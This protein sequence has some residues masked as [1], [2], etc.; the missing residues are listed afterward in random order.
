MEIILRVKFACNLCDILKVKALW[1]LLF[2]LPNKLTGNIYFNP[3]QWFAVV[4]INIYIIHR[5][6]AP[7]ITL[8]K[9]TSVDWLV[10]VWGCFF[11]FL[12]SQCRWFSDKQ[13]YCLLKVVL[14]MVYCL[15]NSCSEAWDSSFGQV[16]SSF[17][18]K[19]GKWGQLRGG[20]P[21]NCSQNRH[22]EK[23]LQTS[24]CSVLTSDWK[25][26]IRCLLLLFH[27]TPRAP[28]ATAIKHFWQSAACDYSFC[29]T[30]SHLQ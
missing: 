28:A 22:K 21:T 29:S 20:T 30:F 10:C 4:S 25:H 18:F 11:F 1:P 12:F 14:W 17:V 6:S 16:G 27:L 19:R 26:F 15:C 8:G 23:I 9:H 7:G 5:P 13:L 2:T 3:H 24:G